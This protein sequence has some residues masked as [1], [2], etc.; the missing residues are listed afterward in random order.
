ME[1]EHCAKELLGILLTGAHSGKSGKLAL[2]MI[3]GEI[4]VL[5]QLQR[6][7]GSATPGQ[8][9]S[10]LERSASRIANT[11]NALEAKGYIRRQHE[12][13]DRRKVMA[14]LTPEGAAFCLAKKQQ[15]LDWFSQLLHILT[16]E[17]AAQY[18]YLTMKLRSG[19]RKKR[20]AETPDPEYTRK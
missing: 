6:M 15:L 9:S 18:L 16:P 20:A 5:Y 4:A 17:E 14:H 19:I 12:S 2:E 13:D 7:G 10:A 3:Q 11:L 1:Y 8:I